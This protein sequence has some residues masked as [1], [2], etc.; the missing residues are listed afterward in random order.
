MFNIG[1]M[2]L[3]VLA[4][5]GLIVLGPDRLPELARDAARMIRALRDMATG[6]RAQ[7]R[8]ELGPE[9]ADLDLRSLHPRAAIQRVV[10][11]DEID[12]S[13]LDPRTAVQRAI[14][15]T[16]E[17]ADAAG[18]ASGVSLQKPPG[19]RPLGRSESAPYDSDAT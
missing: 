16:D 9:F 5:V 10:L 4:L 1:P 13:K 18:G 11:G 3:G 14:F 2:E 12:L 7:L 6:A 8:D 15:G 19:Q 17:S